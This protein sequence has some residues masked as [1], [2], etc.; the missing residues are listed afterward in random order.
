MEQATY[1]G[2]FVTVP[3][4]S[5][6]NLTVDNLDSGTDLLDRSDPANPTYL[7]DGVYALTAQFSGLKF[8]DAAGG[9]IEYTL[10][11]GI[12]NA[13]LSRALPFAFEDVQTAI[14]KVQAGTGIALAVFN[15]DGAG[16]PIDFNVS[17]LIVVKLA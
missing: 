7:A 10:N 17:C 9:S 2:A 8:A 5:G 3:D 16:Q 12:P 6:A 11:P 13:S 4:G 1:S 15:G 14:V